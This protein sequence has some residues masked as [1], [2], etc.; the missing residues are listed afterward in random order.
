MLAATEIGPA[1]APLDRLSDGL[2]QAFAGHG[3]EQ[4]HVPHLHPAEML[5]DI[6]GEDL[7]SRA[8]LFDDPV[9]RTELC[10][11]PDFTVPVALAHGAGGWD[12][13]ASYSYCGTV[14]RR[15]EG[16]TQ[17]PVEFQQAGIESFGTADRTSADAAIFAL[18]YDSLQRHGIH[19]PQATLGDL[20][21]IFAVLDAL[22]MPGPRRAALKR[23]VWRPTRFQ[24]LIAHAIAPPPPS[25]LRAE[26]IALATD[27]RGLHDKATSAAGG[28]ALGQR[29]ML[30]IT[31]RTRTLA[32]AADEPRMPQADAD[33]IAAVLAVQGP[34]SAAADRLDN[35]TRPAGIDISPALERFV[36]R[37]AAITARDV[38]AN[39]LRFD[40]AF[41]RTL[42]YY[43]GF[44]FEIRA[45]EGDNHPPLAGGGR[46]DAMTARLGAV[47]P[48]PAVGAMIRPEAMLE[49]LR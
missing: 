9:Q 12:R 8:F 43:D 23:H 45:T 24:D 17:R 30:E 13:R 46:Y 6:Y 27:P 48:V 14:F 33:V 41:G 3:A 25:A 32:A 20:G 18:I 7:R 47:A 10:L 4:I 34:A 2:T 38:P 31:Q 28:E 49:V 16:S 29:T 22:E 21:I 15:Q 39:A 19:A 5:L 26:V 11:R 44:V 35:A 37:H 1:R 40:A 36:Q 42:E